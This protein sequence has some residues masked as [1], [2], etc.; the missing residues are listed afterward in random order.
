MYLNKGIDNGLSTSIAKGGHSP[1]ISMV[2]ERLGMKKCPKK[3]KK[4]T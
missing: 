1:P 4:K 2:G 3:T